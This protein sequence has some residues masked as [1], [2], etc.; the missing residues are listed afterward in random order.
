LLIEFYK[1]ERNLQIEIIDSLLRVRE[2]KKV[3]SRERLQDAENRRQEMKMMN[4]NIDTKV[5]KTTAREKTF[6][7]STLRQF[8]QFERV[9][10]KT[11]MSNEMIDSKITLAVHRVD[12]VSDRERDRERERSRDQE[13]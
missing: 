13:R 9:L 7:N 12:S 4:I 1:F 5:K 11:T 10:M 6:E 2:S 8:S 3:R